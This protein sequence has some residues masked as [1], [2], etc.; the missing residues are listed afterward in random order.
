LRLPRLEF[1]FGTAQG[2]T[3]APPRFSH[4]GLRLLLVL[5]RLRRRPEDDEALPL[6]LGER[7]RRRRGG[8]G[9]DRDLALPS[10]R[11]SPPPPLLPLRPLTTRT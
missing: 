6:E 5:D 9:G 2:E 8:G 10:R 11:L 7:L 1:S 3:F 4:D